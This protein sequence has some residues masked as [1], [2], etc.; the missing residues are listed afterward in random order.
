[1]GFIKS[2]FVESGW[3]Q[4]AG[5]GML[6]GS[7]CVLHAMALAIGFTSGAL[8]FGQWMEEYRSYFFVI[9]FIFMFGTFFLKI[10]K[11]DITKKAILI[12]LFIMLLTFSTIFVLLNIFLFFV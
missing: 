9:G 4:G 7:C 5:G 10:R 3:F 1:M 11:R 2:K 6:A 8:I 12:H